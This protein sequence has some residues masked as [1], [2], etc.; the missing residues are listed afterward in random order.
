MSKAH[1]V[2]RQRDLTRAL[3]AAIAAGR[4]VEVTDDGVR[5]IKP[6]KR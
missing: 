1:W 4:S 2:F 6:P 3:K 5:Y